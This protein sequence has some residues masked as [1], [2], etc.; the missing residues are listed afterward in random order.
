MWW[1]PFTAT[2]M[3]WWHHYF[4]L[5]PTFTATR[6]MYL[7]ASF[8]FLAQPCTRPTADIKIHLLYVRA[9]WAAAAVAAVVS[10]LGCPLTAPVVVGLVLGVP[11]GLTAVISILPYLATPLHLSLHI[12]VLLMHLHAT[13]TLSPTCLQTSSL[14]YSQVSSQLYFW[15]ISK[16]D[17]HKRLLFRLQ[18]CIILNRKSSTRVFLF[19]IIIIYGNL[20][21]CPRR[22]GATAHVPC[23]WGSRVAAVPT[24]AQPRRLQS[25]LPPQAD[26]APNAYH[27]VRE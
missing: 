1:Q 8:F 23:S 26:G 6:A 22:G 2:R 9:G 19:V 10:Q 4:T 17:K 24:R 15:A 14:Y 21:V 16:I 27:E 20:I 3:M 18:Y 7:K 5:H 25:R 13:R 11:V 12:W